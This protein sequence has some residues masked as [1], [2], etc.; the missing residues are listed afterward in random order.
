MIAKEAVTF[1]VEDINARGGLFGRQLE[2]VTYDVEDVMPEKV[3][4]SS[5]ALVLGEKVDLSITSWID[6]GVDVKAYGRY[7]VP[8]MGGAAT[9]LSLQAYQEAPDDYWNTLMYWPP[10]K[11]YARASWPQLMQLPYEYPNKKIFIVNEDD[12]WSH[13]IADEYALLAEKDGWEVAGAETVPTATVEFG[14][15]LT[16]IKAADPAIVIVISL[17]PAAEAAFMSQFLKD[18]TNSL[19]QMP[20]C[21]AAPEWLTLNGANAEGVLWSTTLAVLPG[22]EGEA[23]KQKFIDRFGADTWNVSYSTGLWDMMHF[24]E[25]AVK[26][27]GSVTDY[28]AIMEYIATNEYAGFNGKYVFPKETNT[29]VGGDDYIPA[30]FYQ[31]QKGVHV[32][33]L[34]EKWAQGEFIVPPWIKK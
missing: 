7:D 12:Q 3:T 31:V 11:E 17:S 20:Y 23:F 4:A 16:K 21:P 25:N 9:T 24:W 32:Q 27:A 2:I 10:E 30:P 19:V 15:T 6:Y 29:V 18:P 34:P 28:K 13:F 26:A 8:Y 22:P 14:A 5:E 1:A 33:L